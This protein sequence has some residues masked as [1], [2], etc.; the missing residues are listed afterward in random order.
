MPPTSRLSEDLVI[1]L[2]IAGCKTPP[3]N[4]AGKLAINRQTIPNQPL[5]ASSGKVTLI[6]CVDTCIV[7]CPARLC[8][9]LDSL[10]HGTGM[11]GVNAVPI[12]PI[13]SVDTPKMTS[14]RSP[15]FLDQRPIKPP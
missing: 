8:V 3:P 7:L 10:Y 2:F 13:A 5:R 9:T 1:K 4:A 15:L 11:R 14:Q 12:R 6:F